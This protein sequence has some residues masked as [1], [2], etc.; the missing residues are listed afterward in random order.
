MAEAT[1]QV[2]IGRKLSKRYTFEQLNAKF[3]NGIISSDAQCTVDEGES[4]LPL[5]KVLSEASIVPPM[6]M[7]QGTDRLRKV[8]SQKRPQIPEAAN[9]ESSVAHAERSR[10]AGSRQA[11]N[12]VL[13]NVYAQT[14][15]TVAEADG[16]LS[17]EDF[18]ET[19]PIPAL[20]E[21]RRYTLPVDAE[22]YE[23][24]PSQT[25]LAAAT[26]L[27]AGQREDASK[28]FPDTKPAARPSAVTADHLRPEAINGEAEPAAPR[29]K[30]KVVYAVIA[31]GGVCAIGLMLSWRGTSG[32]VPTI[33]ELSGGSFAISDFNSDD[34]VTVEALDARTQILGLQVGRITRAI[35]EQS[36]TTKEIELPEL[37]VIEQKMPLVAYRPHEL[38]PEMSAK[39]DDYRSRYTRLVQDKGPDGRKLDEA[40]V[41][42]HYNY[43]KP[44]A[45]AANCQGPERLVAL[46]ELAEWTKLIY[47]LELG[48]LRSEQSNLQQKAVQE[49]LSASNEGLAAIYPEL[50]AGDMRF[51][52]VFERSDTDEQSKLTLIRYWY[53]RA[54]DRN[55]ADAWRDSVLAVVDDVDYESVK[56]SI[57]EVDA[58]ER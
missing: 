9:P 16:G 37:P 25:A 11:T 26:A 47:L 4:F 29:K 14:S 46:H 20:P 58:I 38:S 36:D 53:H 10:T 31:F 50:L 19:Y 6:K 2:R 40:T 13:S 42:N 56:A 44:L 30:F 33:E 24:Q 45:N 3:D 15:A 23:E 55:A 54:V 32:G 41:A 34:P 48:R 17:V 21:S 22:N 57:A 12:D 1:W 5:S 49:I 7:P 18:G 28:S 43:L 8:R 51:V 39:I 35:L 52:D 27:A